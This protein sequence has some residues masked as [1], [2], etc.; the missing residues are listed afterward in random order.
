MFKKYSKQQNMDK[1]IIPEQTKN[2]DTKK[3]SIET[4]YNKYIGEILMKTIDKIPPPNTSPRT[5]TNEFI[6]EE[7]MKKVMTTIQK[8]EAA[9]LSA[10]PVSYYHAGGDLTQQRLLQ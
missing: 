10:I 6:T 1:N 5:H 3:R 9:G 2:D 4:A 7:N 8:D